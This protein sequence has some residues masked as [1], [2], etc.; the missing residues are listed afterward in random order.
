MQLT[1]DRGSLLQAHRME[2]AMLPLG[3]HQQINADA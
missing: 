2:Y 3:R 1:D